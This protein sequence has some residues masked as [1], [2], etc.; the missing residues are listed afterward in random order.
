MKIGNLNFPTPIFLA[1][2]AGVTDTPYR[3]LAREMGCAMAFH[4]PLSLK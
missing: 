3:I 1:P 2:M 4:P